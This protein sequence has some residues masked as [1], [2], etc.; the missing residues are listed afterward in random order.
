MKT[1]LGIAAILFCFGVMMI[2]T[3]ADDAAQKKAKAKMTAKVF[4]K[5]P[6]PMLKGMADPVQFKKD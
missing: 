1:V 4:T 6:D 3:A 2:M 5:Y